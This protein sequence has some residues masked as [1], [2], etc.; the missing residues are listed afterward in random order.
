MV[1]FLRS[2]PVRVIIRDDATSPE[3]HEALK[4]ARAELDARL[5]SLPTGGG[6]DGYGA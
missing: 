3:I 4:A 1:S 5:D 6:S 2:A